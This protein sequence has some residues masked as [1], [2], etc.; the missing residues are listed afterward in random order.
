MSEE[1]AVVGACT[2]SVQ[3][4]ERLDCRGDMTDDSTEI[5][6]QS[7]LQEAIVSSSG[8]V[9]RWPQARGSRLAPNPNK[10]ASEIA[11]PMLRSVHAFVTH[12][13]SRNN[14]HTGRILQVGAKTGWSLWFSVSVDR[15]R[16]LLGLGFVRERPRQPRSRNR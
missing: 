3:C 16:G 6:F 8:S 14:N 12:D 1:A 4:L 2:G 5:L 13:S 11:L 7:V 10:I 15:R 9:R